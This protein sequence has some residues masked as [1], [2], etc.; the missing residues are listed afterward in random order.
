MGARVVVMAEALAGRAAGAGFWRFTR[1][2]NML[3]VAALSPP[4]RHVLWVNTEAIV[5]MSCVVMST[6]KWQKG[7]QI[8]VV[9]RPVSR[10]AAKA[11]YV[12]HA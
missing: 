2:L 9:H 3:L 7:A 4:V 11:A 1:R 8:S 5:S 12:H 6:Q 10:W